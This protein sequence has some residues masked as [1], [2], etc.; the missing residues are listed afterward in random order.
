M[1]IVSLI[2]DSAFKN[3]RPVSYL[4]CISKLYTERAVFNYTYDHIVRSG[5]YPPL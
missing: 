3:L 2:V 5:L 4:A 1:L